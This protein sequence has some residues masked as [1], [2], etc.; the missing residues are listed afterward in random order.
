MTFVIP[1]ILRDI[2]IGVD[3]S[4]TSKKDGELEI[5]SEV[6]DGTNKTSKP[7]ND[8]KEKP[9]TSEEN[10]KEEN[11]QTLIEGFHRLET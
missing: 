1:L 6:K 5:E 7:V 4:I 2:R 3:K 10:V 11:I 9:K 8:K